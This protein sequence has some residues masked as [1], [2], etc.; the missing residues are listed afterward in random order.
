[1]YLSD[2]VVDGGKGCVYVGVVRIWE[3]SI[4]SQFCGEP[5]TTLKKVF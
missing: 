5:K 3:I 4:Y 2:G 1:M